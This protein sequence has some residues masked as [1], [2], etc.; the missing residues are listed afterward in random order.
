M[1]LNRY[2][3]NSFNT[4]IAALAFFA[5][6]ISSFGADLPLSSFDFDFARLYSIRN[7]G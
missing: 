2:F 5:L 1:S 6:T 3:K 4:L 7:D